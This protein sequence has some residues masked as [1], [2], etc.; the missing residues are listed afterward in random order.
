MWSPDRTP[1]GDR[2]PYE[3]TSASLDQAGGPTDGIVDVGRD[4][5]RR[6]EHER[7]LQRK[8]ERPEEIIGEALAFGA[9]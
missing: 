3:I 2:I 9:T 8:N 7:A 6:T 5:T 4:I 1:R